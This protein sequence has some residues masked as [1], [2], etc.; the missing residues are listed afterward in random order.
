MY[1]YVYEPP[2]AFA[3][4]VMHS[5]GEYLTALYFDSGKDAAKWNAVCE[6]KL[7]PIFRETCRWLDIYFS[8]REP[9]FTPRY[10]LNDLTPF[11]KEV[12]DVMNTIGYGRTMS[13]GEIVQRISNAHGG[14]CVSAQAVG[15][16]VGWN[17]ICIVI[18]CHR[19]L[20]TKGKLTGY[21][22]GISNKAAL[23]HH[24]GIQWK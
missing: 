3:N 9:D 1:Q 2:E 8:G 6:M 16:A 20:G 15:G 13:Y 14:K 17:P 5:D 22:G 4:M 19:V 11:R 12:V 18:P 23:L 7:L 21:G 10:R 24:E